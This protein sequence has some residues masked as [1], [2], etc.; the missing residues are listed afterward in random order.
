MSHK[1]R[2]IQKI[3][4]D[5]TC[6]ELKTNCDQDN[7]DWMEIEKVLGEADEYPPDYDGEHNKNTRVYHGKDI[8]FYVESKK[9]EIDGKTRFHEV[10]TKVEIC[11]HK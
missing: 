5:L 6:I 1:D 3:K 4:S 7:P 8:I 2:T 9:I 10:I 11:K